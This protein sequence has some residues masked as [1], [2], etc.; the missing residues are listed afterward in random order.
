MIQHIQLLDT[1][2]HFVIKREAF[3][4]DGYPVYSRCFVCPFCVRV[5]ANISKGDS[6]AAATQDW[7]RPEGVP[8]EL[9]ESVE[10]HIAGSILEYSITF[11]GL[12][13]DLLDALPEP[14]LRR[15]FELTLKA[16]E[17]QQ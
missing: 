1:T 6:L 13:L 17:Q 12:D 7:H 3:T 15:E 2:E 14:L 10:H 4:A 11:N 16:F 5:W 8:C 9:C